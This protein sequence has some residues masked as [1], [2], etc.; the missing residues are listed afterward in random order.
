MW[1]AL[2][3]MENVSWAFKNGRIDSSPLDG[4]VDTPLE[5]IKP[6]MED[7]WKLLYDPSNRVDHLQ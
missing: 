6:A 5:R 3:C 4:L 2:P 1:N 7:K